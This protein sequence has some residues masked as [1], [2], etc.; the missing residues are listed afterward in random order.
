MGC[1]TECHQKCNF[2]S[3][4]GRCRMKKSP[5][6]R[7]VCP[8]QYGADPGDCEHSTCASCGACESS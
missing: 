4:K 7:K 2:M 1:R 8:T 5:N 6:Y 3:G